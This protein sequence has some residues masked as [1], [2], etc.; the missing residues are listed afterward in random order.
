MTGAR[1]CACSTSNAHTLSEHPVNQSSCHTSN[2]HC[3][4]S[5][6]NGTGITS[7]GCTHYH[8]HYEGQGAADT[9]LIRECFDK[10]GQSLAQLHEKDQ[11]IQK[12]VNTQ[13]NSSSKNAEL[14]RKLKKLNVATAKSLKSSEVHRS[15]ELQKMN[16]SLSK[17]NN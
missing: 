4:S 5:N 2:H 13:Q 7:G 3:N 10:M 15:I 14:R 6:L 8:N 12:L 16:Q 9:E 17:E 1:N 11:I